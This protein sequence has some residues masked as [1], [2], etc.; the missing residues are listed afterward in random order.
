IW[1]YCATIGTCVNVIDTGISLAQLI[2]TTHI[3]LISPD[4]TAISNITKPGPHPGQPFSLSFRQKA[5][6][7]LSLC[8][9]LKI[10]IVWAPQDRA[11]HGFVRAKHLTDTIALCPRPLPPNHREPHTVSYQRREAKASAIDTWADR[12]DFLRPRQAHH[13]PRLHQV[14]HGQISP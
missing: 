12:S 2:L 7:L 10:Q 5:D 9:N 13:G 3:L 14:V 11:L 8:R 1:S 4:P 6:I